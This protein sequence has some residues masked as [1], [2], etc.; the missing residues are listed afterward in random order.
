MPK[1]YATNINNTKRLEFEADDFESASLW[2]ADNNSDPS[3]HYIGM[4]DVPSWQ[5]HLY[6][7]VEV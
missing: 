3:I 1:F 6:G 7:T 5:W 2:L 4:I